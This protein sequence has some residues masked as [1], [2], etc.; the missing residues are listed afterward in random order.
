[1]DGIDLLGPQ[2]AVLVGA[3]V[4]LLWDALVPQQRR[5]L[6]FLSLIA[7]AASAAWTLSWVARD[8]YQDAWGGAISLDE[9]AR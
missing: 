5:V 6:P 9:Y 8:D 1:V 2:F 4:V 3:A 7:L